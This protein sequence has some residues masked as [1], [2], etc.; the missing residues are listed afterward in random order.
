MAVVSSVL[1]LIGNTPIVDVSE[2]SPDPGV[3]LLAKLEGQ[4]PAGSVKDRIAAAMVRAAEDAGELAEGKTI[5]EPSSGN[6]GIALAM[7]CRTKGYHLKIV[8]PES[9]TIERRQV[10]ES[11]EVDDDNAG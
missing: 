3:R 9:V 2:L 1:D 11:V 8:L 5:I 6:T 7:V 10:L 4:N